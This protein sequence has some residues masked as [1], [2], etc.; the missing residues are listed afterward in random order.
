MMDIPIASVFRIA[1]APISFLQFPRVEIL[2]ELDFEFDHAIIARV[3]SLTLMSMA[4]HEE[5]K[6]FSV[7]IANLLSMD[8]ARDASVMK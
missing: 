4:I 1:L 2:S 6:P 3:R 8:S 7:G 5:Q